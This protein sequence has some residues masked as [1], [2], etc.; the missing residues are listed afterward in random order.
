M[1]TP[2]EKYEDLKN[3]E[4]LIVNIGSNKENVNMYV[5]AAG[6]LYGQGENLLHHHFRAA[7]LETPEQLPYI[8][9]GKNIIPMIHIRD[10][11]NLVS[12]VILEKPESHYILGVDNSKKLT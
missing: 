2:S 7:W 8:G 9:E 6:M 11:C 1:R 10:L 5:I 12:K 4:N 3:L